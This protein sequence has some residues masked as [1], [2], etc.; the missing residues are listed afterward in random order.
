MPMLEAHHFELL[1]EVYL[2]IWLTST[3]CAYAVGCIMGTGGGFGVFGPFVLGAFAMNVLGRALEWLP[4]GRHLTQDML[5]GTLTACFIGIL[6]S[7]I[8][9]FSLIKTVHFLKRD[10]SPPRLVA[11]VIARP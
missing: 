10:R 6:V 7:S 5:L 11:R 9:S 4:T 8:I 2:L 1:E 3:I